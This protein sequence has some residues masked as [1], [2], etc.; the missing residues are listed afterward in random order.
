[1]VEGRGWVRAD[2]PMLLQT[3]ALDS[4]GEHQPVVESHVATSRR[5]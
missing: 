3:H 2:F 5:S 4:V 1:M